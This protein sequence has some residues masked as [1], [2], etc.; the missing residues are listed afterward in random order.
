MSHRKCTFCRLSGHNINNCHDPAAEEIKR[1]ATFKCNIALQYLGTGAEHQMYQ[2][3]CSWFESKS[4]NELRLMIAARNFRAIGGKHRLVSRAIWAYYFNQWI[5]ENIDISGQVGHRFICRGHFHANI[6]N[7]IPEE[8]AREIYDY[9][10]SHRYQQRGDTEEPIRPQQITIIDG[11]TEESTDC[12][13]CF[14]TETDIIQTNCGHLFCRHCITT[15]T[16]GVATA[17]PCC[18]TEIDLFIMK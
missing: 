7:G 14:E 5:P 3:I 11:L 12:P 1:D 8:R 15:H 13:I 10:L 16:K 9:E 18:R 4:V 2:T 17:C 6:A